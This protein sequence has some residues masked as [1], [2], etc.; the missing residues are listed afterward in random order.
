[1]LNGLTR[2][3]RPWS[4]PCRRLLTG[5]AGSALGSL[6]VTLGIARTEATHFTCLHVG[7]AARAKASAVP[8]GA[9]GAVPSAQCGAL[10]DC[11]RRLRDRNYRLRWRLLPLLP[12]HGWGQLLLLGCGALHGL[13]DG[14][15]VCHGT[16]HP[17]VRLH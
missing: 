6:A 3:R 17:W 11:Q 2:S 13:H 5:V 12:D 10:Y 7:S 9:S 1:M 15:R 14:C 4:L 8:V 16:R